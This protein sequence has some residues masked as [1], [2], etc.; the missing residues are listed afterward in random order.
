MKPRGS[1][2][3]FRLRMA[4]LAGSLTALFVVIACWVLWDLTYRF[5]L[6]TVDSSLERIGRSNLERVSGQSYWRRLDDSLSVLAGGEPDAPVYAIH[7]DNADRHV[8]RSESWPKGFDEQRKAAI[9]SIPL[10][11]EDPPKEPQRGVPVS[12][13]NPALPILGASFATVTDLDG[14]RWRLAALRNHYQSL[15][16]A[17][18]MAAFEKSMKTLRSRFLA[19]LP[20]ALLGVGAMAWWFSQRSLEPVSRLASAVESMSASGLDYRIDLERYDPEY[21]RL[22]VMFNKMLERLESSFNQASRFSSDASHE[23]NTPLTRLQMELESAL[24][25]APAASPQQT[26]Y[27][28]LLDEIGHLKNIA[29]KLSLLSLSDAGTL[30][31]DREKL[32]LGRMIQGVVED[33]KD[34]AADRPLK[35]KIQEGVYIQADALLMEQAFQNLMSNALKYGREKGEVEVLLSQKD[36]YASITVSNEGD[37]IPE[38]EQVRVFDRFYRS[39]V[40]RSAAISGTG[41]GLSLTREILRA[42]GGELLLRSSNDCRTVFEV[43]IHCSDGR[44]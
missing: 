39:D 21:R 7:V 6:D 3:S 22:A 42:H 19:V 34:L 29:H 28:N 17:M 27:S 43:V 24:A 41:L 4:L 12:T 18:D 37:P 35:V 32:D 36:G 30:P 31:L 5:N 14:G 23:L 26:V 11:S 38:S 1:R 10:G 9:D 40:A 15:A 13:T 8:Y 44:A 33:W 16:I 25:E 20:F 2:M